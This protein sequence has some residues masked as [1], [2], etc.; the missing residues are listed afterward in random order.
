MA[1][2]I[3]TKKLRILHVAKWFPNRNDVQNGVFI[4]KH[5]A[6]TTQ[7]ADV[8][9]LAWLQ[10]ESKTDVV[11]SI[12]NGMAITRVYFKKKTAVS[13]KRHAFRNYIQGHYNNK[14]LPDLIHLH[15]FSPDLL[16]VVNWAKKR[17]IPVVIS[18]HWSGYIRGIFDQMP[19]WR[20]MAYRQLAKKVDVILPV[21][22]FLQDHMI[23]CKM[24]GAYQIV[25]NIVEPNTHTPPK[26]KQFSFVVIADLVDEIKNVSGIIRAFE[27]IEH[28]SLL[29]IIG[30]GPD[31]EKIKNLVDHSPKK[32]QIKLYGRLANDE[33]LK[34]LP[35][36]YCL[37][38]NSRVES[39]GV[40]VLEA[41]AAS[42][43]VISTKC[44][45]PDEWLEEGDYA[46]ELD[47][48]NGLKMAMTNVINDKQNQFQFIKWKECLP[49]Q[50]GKKLKSIYEHLVG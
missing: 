46:I 43:P 24:K 12:E 34:L 22:E 16:L 26:Q 41:H 18:E 15:I 38:N 29:H 31:E 10:G 27:S 49:D 45:G 14:E 17:N 21:S 40:T 3:S 48:E 2:S 44:G 50:V 23:A 6:C 37:I 33:V 28:N 25:P 13:Y 1:N 39:F 30:G 5:V 42:I 20:K 47:D 36:F 32:E 8:K 9:V 4:Q 7:F 19:K 11:E 35:T